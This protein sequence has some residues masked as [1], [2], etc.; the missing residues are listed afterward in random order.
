[1]QSARG[2]AE[3][4]RATAL[5][6]ASAFL[7]LD[8]EYRANPAVVRERMYRDAVERAIR[9]ASSVRWIPPPVGGRYNGFRITVGSA[10]QQVTF[11]EEK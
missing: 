8:R 9:V 5:G 1:M 11:V 6:D 3:A 10:G 4:D 7:A 2:A